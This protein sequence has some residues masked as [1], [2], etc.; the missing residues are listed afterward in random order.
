MIKR[1]FNELYGLKSFPVWFAWFSLTFSFP[2][3]R[4][5][6][7][8]LLEP[9]NIKLLLEKNEFIV[10]LQAAS[11]RKGWRWKIGSTQVS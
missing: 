4:S 2:D 8:P 10:G 11:R 6:F 7:L 5:T 1:N 9:T 3:R